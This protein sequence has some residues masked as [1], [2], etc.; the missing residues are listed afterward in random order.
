MHA[1]AHTRTCT[2]MHAHTLT[3]TDACTHACTRKY[4]HKHAQTHTPH[5]PN[6]LKHAHLSLADSVSLSLSLSL[7]LTLSVCLCVF[8]RR[9]SLKES[10]KKSTQNTNLLFGC[11]LSLYLDSE[12]CRHQTHQVSTHSNQ[13]YS[14]EGWPDCARFTQTI[15]K[16]C[17]PKIHQKYKITLFL[18]AFTGF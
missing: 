8:V 2:S 5:K 11:L 17:N 7:S 18:P 12:G 3:L 13:N 6:T 1:H 15:L 10:G 9:K 16:V 14:F 4:T